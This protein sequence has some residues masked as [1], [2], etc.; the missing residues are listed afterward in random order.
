MERNHFVN[1]KFTRPASKICK[2]NRNRNRKFC[3]PNLASQSSS[4]RRWCLLPPPVYTLLPSRF[5]TTVAEGTLAFWAWNH[6]VDRM[7]IHSADIA[8]E[9]IVLKIGPVGA[10]GNRLLFLSLDASTLFRGRCLN[11]FLLILDNLYCRDSRCISFA[12][13]IAAFNCKFLRGPCPALC[14]FPLHYVPFP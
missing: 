9:N 11:G 6:V 5:E 3:L 7:Q 13:K 2:S 12:S 8:R 14:N 1:T 4:F 10:Q